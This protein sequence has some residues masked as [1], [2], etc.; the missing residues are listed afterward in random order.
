MSQDKPRIVIILI[1]AEHDSPAVMQKIVNKHPDLVAGTKITTF[2]GPA[3]NVDDG[4]WMALLAR[5]SNERNI[6]VL[7]PPHRFFEGRVGDIDYAMAKI[8]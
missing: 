1:G 3:T 5:F 4:L 7:S 8:Y 6:D 2:H